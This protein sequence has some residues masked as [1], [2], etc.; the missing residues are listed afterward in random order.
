MW[1]LKAIWRWLR[2]FPNLVTPPETT[3]ALHFYLDDMDFDLSLQLPTMEEAG[4]ALLE[5][6]R[7]RIR[8]SGVVSND[9]PK[10]LPQLELTLPPGQL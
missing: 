4:N 9:C 3:V 2:T 1:R 10:G 7:K 6:P 8:L 5:F